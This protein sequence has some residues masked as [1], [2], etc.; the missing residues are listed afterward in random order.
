MILLTLVMNSCQ[1]N[2]T[3]TE[4][5]TVYA[6]PELYFP[7]YPAP[8]NNVIPY[9]KDFKK[10][11]DVNTEIEYVVMPFWY[12]KLIVDYKVSVDEQKTKY[13]AFKQR[14][15]LEYKTVYAVPELY[16]PKFPAPEKNTIPLDENYKKVTDNDTDIEYVLMPFWYY[17]LIVDY[18]IS[19]DEQKAK[20]EAFKQRLD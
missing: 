7:Q 2:K 15:D 5:K 8:K 1:S 16:F 11:T 12:Y 18:K 14:L 10:V 17:K 19:V 3:K 4:Y 13:E 20:Y 6:V 9:D